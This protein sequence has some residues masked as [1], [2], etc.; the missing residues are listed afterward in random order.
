MVTWEN[1]QLP[2]GSGDEAL[3]GP[4]EA[5]AAG[6]GDD[7]LARA[8]EGATGSGA[9]QGFAGS[10][11]AAEC[12]VRPWATHGGADD[13]RLREPAGASGTSSQKVPFTT[14]RHAIWET[15][16]SQRMGDKRGR[17]ETAESRTLSPH[18]ANTRKLQ[19]RRPDARKQLPS[20]CAKR[21]G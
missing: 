11:S 18:C 7:I 16:Q 19:G 21:I 13:E 4:V 5:A 1:G 17:E 3:A 15:R 12:P 20:R 8:V 9:R 14:N 6:S 10:K 2:T